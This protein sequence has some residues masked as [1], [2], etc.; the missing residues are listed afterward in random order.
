[1][2]K[3]IAIL[4]VIAML[5]SSFFIVLDTTQTIE[6]KNMIPILL[7]AGGSG[8]PT[9]PYQISNVNELQDI[10]TDLDAHYVL[11]NDIDASSTST[12]NGGEG[13]DPLGGDPDHFNGSLVGNGFEIINLFIGRSAPAD[14]N[15]GLFGYLADG[16]SVMN[17]GLVDVDITGSNNAGGFAG[18]TKGDIMGCYASGNVNGDLNTGGLA[19]IAISNGLISN[20]FSKMDI[21][22]IDSNTGGLVGF[23]VLGFTITNCYSTGDVGGISFVGGLIGKHDSMCTVTNSYSISGVTGTGDNVGGFVGLNNG[24][25]SDCHS[26]GNTTST[27][28]YIGGFA[29]YNL[30]P[31]TNS[32]STGSASGN[33]RVGGFI[34]LNTDNI[35]NS[36]SM[37]NASGNDRVGGFAGENQASISDSYSIG[38]ASGT[39]RVGGFAGDD[40]AAITECFWDTEASGTTSSDGGNGLPTAQMM[41]LASFPTWNF[42]ATWGIVEDTTYPFLD[43]LY[44]IVTTL[45]TAQIENATE[46]VIYA[47]DL[48][49]S[50]QPLPSHNKL[51]NWTL[52]T[53]ATWLSIS[54]LNGVVYGL[55]TNDDVGSFMVNITVNDSLGNI[56]YFNYTLVV[57]N[58][59]PLITTM[60]VLAANTGALYNMDYDSSDDPTTTWN[61]TTNSTW[62]SMNQTTGTISGTPSNA[63]AGSYWV[64]VTVNDGNNGN[65][66]TNFTL[67]VNLD[68][69]GDG[70]PDITDLDDDDDGTPDTSD[71]FPLD[72]GEDTDTDGDGTGNNADTDDDGDNWNDSVEIVAGTDPLDNSSMPLDADSDG[73]ANF[74]DPDFLTVIEY[75]NQTL[76]DNQT[77]WSNQT[78]YSNIT[79]YDNNTVY[80][81]NTEYHNR[82]VDVTVGISDA[83]TDSD[84][85][86]DSVEILN[87]TDPLDD[88]FTPSDVDDDGIADFMDP[89]FLGFETIVNN[90]VYDNNTVNETIILDPEII[91][92]IKTPLW[93]YLA[94][95]A[96]I[97]MG[98]LAAAG[99]S[100]KGGKNLQP[101][102]TPASPQMP[103]PPPMM[104]PGGPM[105][106]IEE[107]EIPERP[108]DDYVEQ[109]NT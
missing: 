42:P 75:N 94:L 83:D 80:D 98:I 31:I 96:A 91:T 13:F 6:G 44:P 45:Q 61:L 7:F 103:P 63:H 40:V 25:I 43:T 14:E 108:P 74:M 95:I 73:I 30:D 79:E 106:V 93:A 19:G 97:V 53:N 65:D 51:E 87:G 86:N 17:L 18:T 72:P 10:G 59:P 22:N 67:S 104:A 33:N 8:T 4:I 49:A 57:E 27:G 1:M 85:W 82:T 56:G 99:S 28:D 89:D 107:E 78:I 3:A 102:P 105:G 66:S 100:R 34:G 11:V 109:Q 39:S 84:G 69:D 76:W 88:L 24:E 46:D 71:D 38:N 90:T 21:T 81:N 101:Q 58:A 23:T 60:D 20:C 29:G 37:G 16:A 92:V 9:D 26:T 41:Q 15:I 32:Y 55:P 36:Y 62:L 35:L 54:S 68:S 50:A 5:F 70:V 2:R 48:E 47:V 64:N 77:V 12:W 52:V